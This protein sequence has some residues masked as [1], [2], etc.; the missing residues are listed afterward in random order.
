MQCPIC[1][2]TLPLSSRVCSAC[3]NEYD[4]FFLTEEVESSALRR[5]VTSSSPRRQPAAL[6]PRRMAPLS[7][8]SKWLI[9]V[10][11]LAL[12][13][14]VVAGVIVLPHRAATAGNPADAVTLY[15]RYLQQGDADGLFSVFESGY[16]PMERPRA[17]VRAN[18]SNSKYAVTGP[19]I[20]VVS[21]DTNTAVVQ[22]DD[23]EVDVTARG[24]QTK[25]KLPAG[26]AVMVRINNTGVGWKISGRP[27]NGWAPENLWLIGAVQ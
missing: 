13:L 14:I 1:G 12:T 18:L 16:L 23:V 11:A 25:N 5:S 22:I 3:G 2:E 7:T 24:A 15:Y 17:A 27:V 8:R 21:G 10:G 9:A 20:H 26:S 4:G 6:T 19:T